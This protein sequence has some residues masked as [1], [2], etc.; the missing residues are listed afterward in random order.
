MKY[1]RIILAIILFTT[2]SINTVGCTTIT[3]AAGLTEDIT[4]QSFT[5][6]ST[7]A[8][9]A[10]LMEG[11]TSRSVTDRPVD[12]TFTASLADFAIELFQNSL[13]DGENSLISPLS[14]ML[15]LAMTTNG[16]S[17]E[18]LTEL[19]ELLG[20][21]IP[22]ST[23]N[24]YL[25]SYVKGLPSHEKAKLSIANSIWFRDDDFLQVVPEFLQ[26]NADYYRAQ[27]Y[28]AAFDSK[29]VSDINAWVETNTDSMINSI[30][31]EIRQEG[32]FLIN[33][34]A[35]DAEWLNIYYE[36][37]IKED[38]FT[39]INGNAQVTDFMYSME[40]SFISDN[41]A[42]GFIKPYADNSYSFVAL[43][44]NEGI[45][46][47]AY[48]E[49]LAG[50]GFLNMLENKQVNEVHAFMPKF[51]YEY[52]I[53]MIDALKSLGVREAFDKDMAD[54]NR[55]STSSIGNIFIDEVLHKTFISVDE[56]GTRAGAVTMVAAISDSASPD[57]PKVVRLDRPFLFAIVD[58][59]T[60][61]PIFIG[62]VLMV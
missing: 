46:I 49:S 60:N 37:S 5:N 20:S 55:M 50:S 4:S 2:V 57:E 31:E 14:V 21:G 47:E 13:T 43:L 34:I 1:M 62:T 19:E 33:A 40:N 9:A 22:I 58:N 27:I 53:S 32:M 16:A 23:L 35:F 56:R 41:M 51:E 36:H 17:G 6:S 48:I 25:Y 45:S 39:D 59:K 11:I 52:E 12:G 30:L 26:I 24:E 7:I 42:T 18:T 54:F 29:T 28:R 8:K 61:L 15:A 44:P 3:E 38:V 10:D